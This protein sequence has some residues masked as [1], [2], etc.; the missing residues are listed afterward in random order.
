M[1]S[2]FKRVSGL[3]LKEGRAGT[4]MSDET[5]TNIPAGTRLFVFKNTKKVKGDKQPD[6]TLSVAPPDPGYEGSQKPQRVAGDRP[7]RGENRRP[8]ATQPDDSEIPF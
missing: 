6:Y 7:D 2:D 8:G 4:F 1:A 3:W 5:D